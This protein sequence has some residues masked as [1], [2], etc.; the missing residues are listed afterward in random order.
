MHCGHHKVGTVWFLRVLSPLADRY[1][2]KFVE[3]DIGIPVA[4]ADV[5]L[6]RHS[7]YFDESEFEGRPI[8]GTHVIRDP[9]DVAVSGYNYH[10]WTDEPWVHAPREQFE[11]RSYQEELKRVDAEQGLL[12]EI[13]AMAAIQLKEM[14]EWDYADDRFLELRYE[15]MV[16]DEAA[17]FAEV[18]RHYGLNEGATEVAMKAVER[19]S[20]KKVTGR[21]VGEVGSRSHLR[22]GRP[23]EW[24]EHFEDSHV[25]RLKNVAPGALVK[26]GYEESDD[27]S[28]T[29]SQKLDG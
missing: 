20:F 27:W 28:V 23:G 8:R 21:E 12:L 26:L 6:C 9:R 4:G 10:L 15:D 14:L 7:R 13:E 25:E 3:Q 18:F 2:L 11:G 5:V 1:G 29:R 24:R 16:A 17:I 22:S 19:A